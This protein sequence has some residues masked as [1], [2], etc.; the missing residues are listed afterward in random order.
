MTDDWFSPG[1]VPPSQRL[2]P[3]TLGEPLWRLTKSGHTAEGRVRA[4]GGIGLELRYEWDGDLRV[5]QM[6]K[7]WDDLEAVAGEKRRELQSKGWA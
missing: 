2:E 4:I 7:M 1:R 3:V 6:F 5:S